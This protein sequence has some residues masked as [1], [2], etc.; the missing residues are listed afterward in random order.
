MLSRSGACRA[1][2]AVLRCGP[3]FPSLIIENSLYFRHTLATNLRRPGAHPKVVLGILGHARVN[4]AMYDH[5][6]V[7]DFSAV[8]V[9][10]NDLLANRPLLYSRVMKTMRMVSAEGI[11]P[12]TY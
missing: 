1:T 7:Q 2:S 3:F 12:S 4:L 5:T 8:F 6:D 11:E 10:V 9:K